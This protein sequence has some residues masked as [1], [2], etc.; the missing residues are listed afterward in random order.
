MHPFPQTR[1]PRPQS[2]TP[3]NVIHQFT[4]L[5]ANDK[6]LAF[7]GNVR[8]GTDVHQEELRARYHSVVLAY[9]AESDRHLNV[10]GEVG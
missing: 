10:P 4:N 3:Q 6:R 7:F 9:G 8:L 1:A 2:S 5:M